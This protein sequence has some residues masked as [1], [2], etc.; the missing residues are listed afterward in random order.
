M[1]IFNCIIFETHPTLQGQ[2][3][4]FIPLRNRVTQLY[5]QA[6]GPIFFASY[7]SQDYG[8]GIRTLLQAGNPKVCSIGP[9]DVASGRTKQKTY[10]L[11]TEI[12]QNHSATWADHTENTAS[13]SSN[14]ARITVAMLT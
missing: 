5:I 1:T 14:V 7:E 3:S 8:G 6:L 9:H 12:L 11:S 13:D 2:V 4:V 10:F